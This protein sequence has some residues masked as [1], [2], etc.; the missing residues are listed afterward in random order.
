METLEDIVGALEGLIAWKRDDR[1]RGHNIHA[2]YAAHPGAAVAI[3]QF[4]VD[5]PHA[6]V[7]VVEAPFYPPKPTPRILLSE[8]IANQLQLAPTRSLDDRTVAIGAAIE[9]QHIEV[10]VILHCEGFVNAR[11]T[12]R[13]EEIRWIISLFKTLLETTR[14]M[15]LANDDRGA[16]AVL[17]EEWVSSHVIRPLLFSR[18]VHRQRTA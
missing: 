18:S 14:L 10:L 4:V 9:R 12:V 7:L 15:L 3:N 11:K 2:V 17:F 5:T 6:P 16:Y 1:G 8:V 13:K